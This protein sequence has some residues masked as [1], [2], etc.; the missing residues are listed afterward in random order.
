MRGFRSVILDGQSL[1]GV[2]A[3]ALVLL[4]MAALFAA[5][6]LSRFR[7]EDTKLSWS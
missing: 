1:G 5:V 7:F 2:V 3:P 4:G 6:A